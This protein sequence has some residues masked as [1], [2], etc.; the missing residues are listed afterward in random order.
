PTALSLLYEHEMKF[1]EAAKA[2]GYRVGL[3]AMVANRQAQA[4]TRGAAG[5]T[6]MATEWSGREEWFAGLFA[7]PSLSGLR[8]AKV[9]EP[10]GKEEKK[11]TTAKLETQKR[12]EIDDLHLP[13]PPNLLSTIT[14]VTGELIPV[15]SSLIGHSSR[16]V[17]NA[18]VKWLANAMEK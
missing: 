7:D 13:H 1:G 9:N 8:E 17:H 4:I 10:D 16:T 6:L 3:K 12:I 18:A 5:A 15:V 14:P 11:G 2:E